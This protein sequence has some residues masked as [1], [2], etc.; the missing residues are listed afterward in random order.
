MSIPYRK[1]AETLLIP[2]KFDTIEGNRQGFSLINAEAL[3]N[4]LKKSSASIKQTCM[5]R[6][7]TLLS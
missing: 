2:L 6:A 3:L 5:A 4:L 7:H 1:R